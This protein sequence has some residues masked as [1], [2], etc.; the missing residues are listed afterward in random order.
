[1]K[2]RK[3]QATDVCMWK[4]NSKQLCRIYEK[5]MKKSI[6]SPNST[7]DLNGECKGNL[8]DWEND[9]QRGSMTFELSLIE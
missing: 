9:Q 1:M 5:H 8:D 6:F 3:T 2:I 7:F 4:I